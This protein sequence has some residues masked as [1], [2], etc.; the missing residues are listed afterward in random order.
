MKTGG[1]TDAP[2][3]Q[4]KVPNSI[5]ND[6]FFT[7]TAF[8]LFMLQLPLETMAANFP[9]MHA[10][11][12]RLGFTD[13]ASN[14]IIARHGFTTID[15]LSRIHDDDVDNLS[16]MLSRPGGQ[17]PNPKVPGAFLP[18]PGHQVSILAILNLKLAVFFIKHR[19]R[20]SRRIVPDDVEVTPERIL[21]L[22][23]LRES[24]KAYKDDRLPAPSEIFNSKDWTTT[25]DALTELLAGR[26]G[27]TGLPLAWVV[28]EEE[29]VADDPEPAADDFGWLTVEEEMIN[30]APMLLAAGGYTAQFKIDNKKVW[31][32]ISTLTRNLPCRVHIEP[33]KRSCNGRGAFQALVRQFLGPQHYSN[34][35]AAAEK[36][37]QETQYHGESKKH[38]FDAYV[39]TH[40]EQHL[41]LEGLQRKGAHAGIH[42]TSKIRHFIKGIKNPNLQAAV[43][44]A[45][46]NDA[47]KSDFN[48]CTAFF[49]DN[50]MRLVS[51]GKPPL[52]VSSATTSNRGGGNEGNR[53]M[54]PPIDEH[55][56]VLKRYSTAQFKRLTPAA[57]K[58]LT[59]LR[60]TA[61][62][63]IGKKR[64]GKK[65]SNGGHNND[66]RNKMQ[67][68]AN[69]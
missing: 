25:I 50:V 5:Y 55:Q 53:T 30:R 27:T 9:D 60:N 66:G 4:P 37:L 39:R 36:A 21:A 8:C 6:D 13:A 54:L 18:N 2:P 44:I 58:K 49:R 28:R 17:V 42:E 1:Q 7:F 26:K 65:G 46:A 40:L 69:V 15:S 63:A 34:Q 41:I 51:D 29:T 33:Y 48:L 19:K 43:I 22:I 20:C 24:E 32:I 67:R 10:M 57:K 35:A 68:T 38:N 47:L 64:K 11:Y 61:E 3:K 52:N 62:I 14:E 45:S 23:F 31:D 59:A 16:K 12:V 56:V